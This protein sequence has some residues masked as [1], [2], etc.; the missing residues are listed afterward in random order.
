MDSFFRA[1]HDTGEKS[2]NPLT[3]LLTGAGQQVHRLE[4]RKKAL[5]TKTALI[6]EKARI[7]DERIA[8]LLEK[9]VSLQDDFKKLV[10]QEAA[11]KARNHE[12]EV[13]LQRQ[14]HDQ[15]RQ[16]AHC[17]MVVRNVEAAGRQLVAQECDAVS[18]YADLTK[19]ICQM[20]TV[21]VQVKHATT[22]KQQDIELAATKIQCRQSK[23]RQLEACLQAI[24]TEAKKDKKLAPIVAEF[25]ARGQVGFNR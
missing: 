3:E 2:M 15:G 4:I 24:L 22:R 12:L 25:V 6:E 17:T 9:N 10:E 11:A 18:R 13:T 1:K 20:R 16:K 19:V 7:N 8:A 14:A 23:L 5:H 21:R